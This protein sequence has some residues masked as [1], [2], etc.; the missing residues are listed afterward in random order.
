MRGHPFIMLNVFIEK[1]TSNVYVIMLRWK[2]LDREGGFTILKVLN[3]ESFQDFSVQ[4]QS[5]IDKAKYI[6]ETL[7]PN[8]IFI[9][10]YFCDGFF[11]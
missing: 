6:N 4:F 3:G 7:N 5:K 9:N 8:N 1:E 11:I 2:F 10:H